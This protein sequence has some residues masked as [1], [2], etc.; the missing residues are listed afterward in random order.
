M[1]VNRK[2]NMKNIL[3]KNRA[4]VANNSGA[5]EAE[6]ILKHGRISKSHKSRINIYK[7]LLFIAIIACAML[8]TGCASKIRSVKKID[9]SHGGVIQKPVIADLTVGQTKVQGTAQG[10]GNVETIKAEAVR[11]ALIKAGNADVMIEPDFSISIKGMNAQVEVTGFPGTYKNFRT[12]E[13]NDS[14]WLESMEGIYQARIYDPTDK[15][16]T[17]QRSNKGRV[18]YYIGAGVLVVIAFIL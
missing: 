13:D 2:N 15:Q 8:S 12:I 18:W 11:D 6:T 3:F 17:V 14:V 1:E 4:A 9:I 5:M 10:K 16:T 7:N